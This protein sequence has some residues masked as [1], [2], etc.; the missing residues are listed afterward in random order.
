MHNCVHCDVFVTSRTGRSGCRR[1]NPAERCQRR[2]NAHLFR[3]RAQPAADHRRAL[4]PARHRLSAPRRPPTSLPPPPATTAADQSRKH[5]PPATNRRRQ[6]VVA[7]RGRNQSAD[8]EICA[9]ESRG[10][11]ASPRAGLGWTCGIP[12]M[13]A[14]LLPEGVSGSDADPMSFFR[15]S[16]SARCEVCTQDPAF[17]SASR[18]R[19]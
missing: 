17:G 8:E 12:P 19:L 3:A 7:P 11:G 14:P 6:S 2:A 18:P 9:G 5:R 1:L 10:E 4:Q 16:E 15:G 13:F